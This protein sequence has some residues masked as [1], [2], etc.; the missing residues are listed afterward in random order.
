MPRCPR[1]PDRAPTGRIR[2]R[3]TSSTADP[4]MN[5]PQQ[6]A[7]RADVR[8]RRGA[9]GHVGASGEEPAH[10]AA[11]RALISKRQAKFDPAPRSSSSPLLREDVGQ[12]G[13]QGVEAARPGPRTCAAGMSANSSLGELDPALGQPG[14]RP[15][16]AGGQADQRGASVGRDAAPRVTK[17]VSTSAST[18]PV[19]LRALTPSASASSR[20]VHGSVLVQRARPGRPGT[21]SARPRRGRVVMS[22]STRIVSRRISGRGPRRVAASVSCAF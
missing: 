6:H 17:P 1:E 9:G 10:Q 15:R 14:R 8:R 16:P 3:A 5:D 4:I 12:P 2:C 22:S 18:R 7:D 20:W 11:C 19:T 13:E 21:W